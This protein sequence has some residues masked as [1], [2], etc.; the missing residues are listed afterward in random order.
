MSILTSTKSRER[1]LIGAA[2]VVLLAFVLPFLS[3]FY[4]GSITLLQ[5]E[6]QKRE[7]ELTKLRREEQLGETAAKRLDTLVSRSMA[8][9]DSSR[10]ANWLYKLAETSQIQ[11]CTLSPPSRRSAGTAKEAF[12]IL[13]YTL[14][15]RGSLTA[16]TAFLRAF[17]RV[18]HLHLISGITLNPVHESQ[19]I[20][21]VLTIETAVFPQT[22]SAGSLVLQDRS[23]LR[24][25]EV[26]DAMTKT[27]VNRA[28]FSN[29]RSP[30]A[31]PTSPTQTTPPRPPEFDSTPYVM[32]TGTTDVDGEAMAWIHDRTTDK[33]VRYKVGETFPIGGTPCT[34][35]EV[36][37][38][39]IIVRALGELYAIRVG[40]SFGD[41]EDVPQK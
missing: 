21:I 17:H 7:D 10:Y 13:T 34:L 26:E 37:D 19:E 4:G 1:I 9:S 23:S 31:T 15:G 33:H 36:R 25:A 32:L 5:N 40:K 20:N 24:S 22:K 6:V 30:A 29:Y 12:T 28:I 18:D 38:D 8:A 35:V 14:R 39:R 16:L 11:N 3:S 41:F 27:I 2:F